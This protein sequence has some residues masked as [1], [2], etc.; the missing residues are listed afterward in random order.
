MK[1]LKIA[2]IVFGILIAVVIAA[3]AYVA[4]TFDANRLKAELTRVVQEKKQRTLA[5]DGEL[6]LSFWPN[7]GVRLGHTTLSEHASAE[8]F[9]AID[10]ARVSVAVMPLLSKQL[11]VDTVELSGVQA[12]LVRRKDGTLNID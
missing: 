7:V 2:A 8:T 12:T 10:A 4:A 9:A 1:V 5:I 3:A 11:V 6:S